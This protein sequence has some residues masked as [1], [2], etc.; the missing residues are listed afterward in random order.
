MPDSLNSK[1]NRLPARPGV[2]LF[3]DKE[4]KVIYIGKAKVLRSRVKSY[5]TGGSDG[6]AH[7][8]SLVRAINDLDIIATETEIEALI[9]EA[10]LIKRYHPA[11]IFIF[12]MISSFHF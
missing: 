8:D 5:F 3:K 4:G 9:L 1:L 7:Y 12:G 11:S 10:N 6:R 2:Y